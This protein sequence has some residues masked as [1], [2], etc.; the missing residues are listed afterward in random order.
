MRI[1]TPTQVEQVAWQGT[2]VQPGGVFRS[3]VKPPSASIGEPVMWKMDALQAQVGKN[4][5]PP[6]D[7]RLYA[8]VRI[9]FTLHPLDDANAHYEEA[10]LQLFLRPRAASGN[11]IALDLYPMQVTADRSGKI[12]VTLKPDLKFTPAIE[13]NP[14]EAGVEIEHHDVFP[15]IQAFGV[16]QSNPYW[17]F[18]NDAGRKLIGSQSVYFVI[19][20]SPEAQGAR[21]S[22]ELTAQARG[23]LGIFKGGVPEDARANLSKTIV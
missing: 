11:A 19:A 17:M 14:G 6:A 12:N 10:Q 5:T 1:V 16:G 18:K 20:V 4:W 15:V 21:M 8:L 7:G 22:V 13:F 23:R 9:D 2:L 3:G